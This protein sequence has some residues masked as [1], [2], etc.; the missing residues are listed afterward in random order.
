MALR[1]ILCVQIPTRKTLILPVISAHSFE[2][3]VTI[4]IVSGSSL[5]SIFVISIVVSTS[6]LLFFIY[7]YRQSERNGNELE[8]VLQL[9][10]SELVIV[11]TIPVFSPISCMHLG[12]F[13]FLWLAIP[14]REPPLYL[15]QLPLLVQNNQQPINR[16][17]SF[18]P[19][20]TLYSDRTKR[21]VCLRRSL[22][23]SAKMPYLSKSNCCCKNH[24]NW[25]LHFWFLRKKIFQLQNVLWN[26]KINWG[27]FIYMDS[28]RLQSIK[29]TIYAKSSS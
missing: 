25:Q 24:H 22:F 17:D 27:V 13:P 7:F 12:N 11:L 16:M 5:K 10:I 26:G 9:F 23:Y 2:I 28:N 14:W 18:Q 19:E 20:S 21:K 3:S 8:S 15:H 1:N 6:N 4:L 29:M